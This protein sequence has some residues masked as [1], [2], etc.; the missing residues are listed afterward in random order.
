[1]RKASG[2]HA[3]P[4][5]VRRTPEQARETIL[6]AA[7]ALLAERGPDAVGLKDVA[8]AA[9]VSHGLIS[10]YFGTYEG[11]VE[12]T[13]EKQASRL[14]E[15]LLRQMATSSQDGPDAWIA[16]V[17]SAIAS[18]LYGRLAGWALLSGRLERDDF[19]ARREQGLRE[20][21]NV[22]EARY[23]ESHKTLPFS[24]DDLEFMLMLV[25]VAAFGY[26]L[27]RPILW[28]IL[29]REP[30]E[31]RDAWFRER[32]VR[33]VERALLGGSAPAPRRSR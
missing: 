23:R 5:R 3:R 33:L 27:G 8:T 10:H 11:L 12:Q 26:S 2:R 9:G 1:V 25:L 32:L 21:A 30:S 22:V 15:T 14:R 4:P 20:I 29:G 6:Q 31:E 28:A 17:F 7:E 13:L 16:Q 19:F 18:P 24:R